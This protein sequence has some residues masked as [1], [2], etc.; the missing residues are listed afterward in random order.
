VQ[1]AAAPILIGIGFYV[2]TWIRWRLDL[3][4]NWDLDARDMAPD[5]RLSVTLSMVVCYAWA[6]Y[7]DRAPRRRDA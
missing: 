1:A 7:E 5:W 2:V 6:A 3:P 4:P